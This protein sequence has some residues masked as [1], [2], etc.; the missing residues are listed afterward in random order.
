MTIADTG[1]VFWSINAEELAW[2]AAGLIGQRC[3]KAKFTYG[4]ELDLHLGDRVPYSSPRMAGR[5]HGAWRF[6]GRASDWAV[7]RADQVVASTDAPDVAE[8]ALPGR[9]EG[10]AVS[11]FEPSG[12]DS[13]VRITF[14]NASVLTVVPAADE[15]W[16]LAAWELFT[17]TH[18]VI[19]R[20]PG[21][22]WEQ[23]RSDRRPDFTDAVRDAQRWWT[24]TLAAAGQLPD[25]RTPWKPSSLDLQ[26]G[27]LLDGEVF[28]RA[29]SS[30]LAKAVLLCRVPAPSVRQER[31]RTYT[32][33]VHLS[34][35]VRGECFVAVCGP[36]GLDAEVRARVAE[37]LHGHPIIAGRTP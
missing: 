6:G 27:D 28:F 21:L 4:N 33:S 10:A 9:L 34:A 20:G 3:W 17:P 2:A 22:V 18:F 36:P 24:E 12:E 26:D 19:S 1:E 25:W 14:D 11:A 5:E 32:R 8:A 35:T 13:G 31:L 23:L 29:A 30:A 16:D 15:D 7:R 37:F